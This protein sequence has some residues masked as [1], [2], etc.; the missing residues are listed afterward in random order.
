MKLQGTKSMY[1]SPLHFYV[2][3]INFFKKK[4]EVGWLDGWGGG[5]DG[6]ENAGNCT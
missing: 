4:E 5:C 3:T 1:K 6:E 2:L